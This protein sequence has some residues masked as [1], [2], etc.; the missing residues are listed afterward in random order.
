MRNLRSIFLPL[1]LAVASFTGCSTSSGPGVPG[2]DEL[3]D[4]AC[5]LADGCAAECPSDSELIAAARAGLIADEPGFYEADLFFDQSA[6]V[7]KVDD[8]NDDGVVD[9]LVRPGMSYAGANDET[10]VFL[11]ENGTCRASFAGTVGGVT[12]VGPAED[13]ARTDG[14]LDLMATNVSN[15]EALIIRFRFDFEKG[16]FV[17]GESKTEFCDDIRASAPGHPVVVDVEPLGLALAAARG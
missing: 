13:G 10:T 8:L 7:E 17:E 1:G 6:W 16:R 5:D 3:S 9:Y 14:V 12:D 11:S 15:C 2:G 4:E